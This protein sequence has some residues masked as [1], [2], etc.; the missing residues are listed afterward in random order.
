MSRFIFAALISA[1]LLSVAEPAVAQQVPGRDLLDFP[2]GLLAESPPLSSRMAGS[3]WNPAAAA[4]P[5]TTRGEVG[6]AGLTTPKEQGVTLQMVAGEYRLA[7]RTTVSL[8][9]AQASVSD[10]FRTDTDP[11]TLGS[12]IRYATSLLSA[13]VAAMPVKNLSIGLSARYRW[14]AVDTSRTGVVALDGGAILDRVGGTPLRI[15][16]STF[17]FSPSKSREAATYEAAADLPVF[18]R[19]ST[20][21][22]RAGVSHS[23][24]EGRGRDE[25]G[26]ST[27][28]FRQFDFSAGLVESHAYGNIDQR[29]RLGLGLRYASYTIAFGREDGSAGFPASYQ[30]LFTRIFK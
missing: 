16:L 4:L 13:G 30:F 21:M 28:S 6:F 3:L 25:Y 17:L 15:A 9:Y 20:L 2:L 22:V 1:V 14:A 12:E 7:P 5:S 18:R 26:F 23:Q 27:A 24:T 8:S 10:I 19:D 29:F 11:Q